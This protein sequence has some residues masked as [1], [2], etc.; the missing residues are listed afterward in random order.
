MH[1]H[2]QGEDVHAPSAVNSGEPSLYHRARVMGLTSL[3]TDEVLALLW[4]PQGPWAAG[5]RRA[6]QLLAGVP[7]YRVAGLG[8]KELGERGVPA[9]DALRLVCALDLGVR[10][11][12]EPVEFGT[13]I[14]GPADVA[15]IC[16]PKMALLPRERVAV[17]LLDQKRRLLAECVVT[18]G[19][20]EGAPVD[21]REVLRQAI[22]ERASAL[23]LV[24]NHPSGDPT[25]S[26]ADREV[27]RRIQRAAQTVGVKLLDHVVVARGGYASL[28]QLLDGP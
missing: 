8:L 1:T 20:T 23:I 3:Q 9:E 18:E 27:T 22:A 14:T 16:S 26:S 10:A 7:L 4:S 6:Q 19:W 5:V 17:L 13:P 28:T 24:H 21:P 12:Q 25:P 11:T 2:H 15:A